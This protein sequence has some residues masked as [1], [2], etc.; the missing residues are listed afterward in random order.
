M[1]FVFF[2]FF[3]RRSQTF[4]FACKPRVRYVVYRH[5]YFVFYF[6]KLC[7]GP[8]EIVF[9]FK[10]K[11]KEREKKINVIVLFFFMFVS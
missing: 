6:R 11:Y 8:C 2:F 9:D 7:D 4:R 10:C 1:I 5:V 3:P